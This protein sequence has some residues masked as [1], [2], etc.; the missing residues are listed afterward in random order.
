MARMKLTRR[1]FLIA[2]GLVGGGLAVAYSLGNDIP[3]D[4]ALVSTTD[5]GEY[6]LNAWVKI[7]KQGDISVAISQAEMGQGV[8]TALCMLVAEELEVDVALVKPEP[9]PI[10]P[11]YANVVAIMDSLPFSDGHHSGE[12]TVGAWAMKQVGGLLGVQV[13]GGSTSVRNFWG[14]MQQAGA[15][16]RE[17]LKQAAA[18][19]WNVRPDECIAVNGKIKLKNRSKSATYGELV[20]QASKEEAPQDIQLKSASTRRIIGKSQQ[21]LDI[22]AKVTGEAG[23]GVD[24]TL[25]NMAYAAVKLSPVFGGTVTNWDENAVK[26]MPGFIKAVKFKTGIA[27]IANS[28]WRAKKAVEALPV[29]F[30][31]GE[32]VHLSTKSIFALFENNI[33]SDDGRSYSDEGDTKAEL[34]KANEVHSATYKVPFLAHACMEPM[35]CTAKVGDNDVEVWVPNQSSTLM[36]WIAEQTADV[37]AE[38]VK[39]HNTYLG[40]G[41][42]RRAETDFVVMAVTIAKELKNRPVKLIWTR[43]NDIQHDMYRPAALSKFSA[44]LDGN[45]RVAAWHNRVASPSVTRSFVNRL[46]PSIN[47]DMPDNTTAEGSADNPYQFGNKLMEHF[48]SPTAIPVG[49]WRSVG[50]SYNAFFT[51]SFMDELAWAAKKD[52]VAFRMGHLGSHDDFKAVLEK[53]AEVSDW[54]SPLPEGRGRGIALHESFGSIVGQVVEVTVG[55]DKSLRVDKVTCVIDCGEVL[56]PDGVISQMESGII[57]GLSAALFGEITIEN[58]RVVEENFPDYDMVRLENCPEISVHLAP[59]GRPLGGAG[60]PATP[61]IAPALTNAIFAANKDRIREL[62]LSKSGYI[63]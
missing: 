62:P 23:F 29:T 19:K 59:S 56:N 44:S 13:T 39:V 37:P 4:Q 43:E 8:Y 38:N 6:A 2:G 27:V 40:G 12:A 52:P 57:F 9:A 55:A 30:D 16:A 18:R 5:A 10:H 34:L 48:P 31:S 36:G 49:Y 42:G 33:E 14:P 21:R 24:V 20:E 28:F 25:P 22:P 35:N 61:P 54:N 46:F 11:V 41:F 17:M 51:E 47:S 32:A 15:T 7:N 58:G 53:L 26:N 3:D 1:K 50:H 60:E 45:G 63:I